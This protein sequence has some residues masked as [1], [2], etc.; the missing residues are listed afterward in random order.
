MVYKKN[1]REYRNIFLKGGIR[2]VDIGEVIYLAIA[3]FI[4][5]A[6]GNFVESS[7]RTGSSSRSRAF[8]RSLFQ[9]VALFCFVLSIVLVYLIRV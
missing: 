4:G 9:F 2:V 1:N 3:V 8:E 7:S 6:F 5:C